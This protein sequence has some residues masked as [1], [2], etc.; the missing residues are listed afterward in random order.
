M[1]IQV[2][3]LANMW[4]ADTYAEQKDVIDIAKK[5]LDVCEREHKDCNR[6]DENVLPTRLISIAGDTPRL[7]LTAGW[8]ASPRHRYSTLSHRW[9]DDEFL[10]LTEDNQDSLLTSIPLSELPKT[11]K[12]A[13][14]ISQRI[15][16][17][18][19]WIDSLCI[20][21][22]NAADWR[23]EAGSMNSVYGNS[24][25]NIAAS[26]A[27]SVH[28]G[29]F[30][31]PSS[32]VDGLRIPITI[33]GVPLVREFR[34]SSV[35]DLSTTKSHLST[36]A[37]ALQERVLP[38]RTIHFGRRGAFWECRTTTANEFLPGGFP[39]Q[40]GIGL[41]NERIRK[42]H[43]AS[44]WSD[45][46]RLYSKANL[47]FPSDRLPAL[48]GIARRAHEEGSGRYLAGLWQGQDIEAQLC[49]HVRTP[50]VRPAW[51]APSWSWA[52]VDGGVSY[53]T[54]QEGIL[55]TVY[56]HVLEGEVKL[57]C[58]NPFGEVSS[59][60]LRIA[61]SGML[62]ARFGEVGTVRIHS[63]DAELDYL[64]SLDCLDEETKT[65]STVYLMPLLGGATGCAMIRKGDGDDGE[66]ERI[67][68][69]MVCGL[70]LKMREGATGHFSRVGSFQ[71][72]KDPFTRGDRK[73]D[74][75]FDP[76]MEA[77]ESRAAKVAESVCVEV[78]EN[79]ENPSERYVVSVF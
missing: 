45:V 33:N 70:I 36:R 74:E 10:K 56:A 37:W 67:N 17:E 27:E 60:S 72:Y 43:F 32:M 14:D 55:D 22:G 59:G 58:E 31:K 6:I 19:L 8:E 41:L 75:H 51:R 44:W 21:Q 38:S 28:E 62:D 7:V 24:Y 5:W 34:S 65:D 42:G 35:Y 20:V 78:V 2:L 79:A 30:L 77:F 73:V 50:R 9:G 53:F 66:G 4:T 3:W 76:F 40:L 15:G 63:G 1:C 18:Y 71:F 12:D 49:W 39:K 46:V 26:S 16:L 64:V 11:F 57:A 68:E 29:C 69:M 61:C 52:S 54:R 25:L 47:T 23:R 13:I 48:C